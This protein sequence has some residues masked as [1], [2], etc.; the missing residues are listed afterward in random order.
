MKRIFLIFATSFLYTQSHCVTIQGDPNATGDQTFSF[1]L[2][3]LAFNKKNAVLWTFTSDAIT[4]DAI[5]P[6]GI[7]KINFN[8]SL[9]IPLLEETISITS[10]TS[11]AP[12]TLKDQPNPLWGHGIAHVYMSGV[13]QD[14]PMLYL[15]DG[16]ET[17]PTTDVYV[18]RNFTSSTPNLLKVS[19][20]NNSGNPVAII[21]NL[22]TPG[23]ALL[24]LCAA[25]NATG[26]T[27]TE[28]SF[29]SNIQ[30]NSSTGALEQIQIIDLAT[31]VLPQLSTS[32]QN[33]DNTNTN[34]CATLVDGYN[35][36]L[37]L[38]LIAGPGAPTNTVGIF[39][40]QAN[41][42][43]D[44]YSILDNNS[45]NCV[46]TAQN[47]AQKQT[48]M[49]KQMHTST[50]LTYLV[51][52][53][54]TGGATFNTYALPI[55]TV[56]TNYGMIAN[57][58]SIFEDVSNS[59]Q[60]IKSRAFDTVLNT[61]TD[62]AQIQ[63]TNPAIVVGQGQVPTGGRIENM[64]VYGDSVYASTVNGIYFSQALFNPNGTLFNWT[65]WRPV[66]GYT[67]IGTNIN[68]FYLDTT[69]TTGWN[70]ETPVVEGAVSGSAVHKTEWSGGNIYANFAN[71]IN[72]YLRGVVQ[73]LF[74]LQFTS[75]FS[76]M[77]ATG[78]DTVVVSSALSELAPSTTIIGN[79]VAATFA[80]DTTQNWIFVGGQKGLGV[81]AQANGA[82][83][84]TTPTN[85]S[86][87]FPVGGNC[88]P[89]GNFSYIKKLQAVRET[90]FVLQKD[91]VYAFTASQAKFTSTNP[92]DLAVTKI[93]DVQEWAGKNAY[94]TD[95]ISSRFDTDRNQLVIGT[96]NGLFF[97][98]E[99]NGASRIQLPNL[100][101][102]S[103]I[104]FA[105]YGNGLTSTNM[106]VLAA[107]Y[108]NGQSEIVRFQLF[109][110]SGAGGQAR[111]IQDYKY[112]DTL[113]PFIIYRYFQNTFWTNGSFYLSTTNKR[114]HDPM[115][116]TVMN[117]I[118]GYD[119][120]T[121]KILVY[122]TYSVTLPTDNPVFASSIVQ[123][124]A[125]GVLLMAGS[126]G[127]QELS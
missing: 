80:T 96:T 115:I 66:F 5:K 22:G 78:K 65:P 1:E 67:G 119:S 100:Q 71:Y 27:R 104:E 95:M 36:Y 31:D 57:V 72:Q 122:N 105:A 85:L 47:G 45:V 35:M 16:S 101:S 124:P 68:S 92:A 60:A 94:C 75:T 103:R 108:A 88:N 91:G 107:D 20:K 12:V 99:T 83:F 4:D 113:S 69:S 53:I 39:Y 54:R 55:V 126:F 42:Q 17:N 90:V 50:G 89:I 86:Q 112:V 111:V 120:S 8:G 14:T 87:V 21:Q 33:I 25:N 15:N 84:S 51:V 114:A 26:I 102:V 23:G 48:S 28:P 6:Y 97:Y 41:G 13:D 79:T 7:S 52:V 24:T 59:S 61:A 46:L 32:A 73:G 30:T 118:T 117:G 37:G 63:N 98:D 40:R 62:L 81:F 19:P 58:N 34:L 106:Y 2:T 77:M 93:F 110:F 43:Y 3:S 9:A 11:G 44:F 56:P 109:D 76:I 64:I 74:A 121:Q 123:D 125:T 49:I 18:V 10:S 70:M 127:L 29:I 116:F 82:G 38:D